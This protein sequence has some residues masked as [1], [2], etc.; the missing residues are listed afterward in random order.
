[1]KLLQG[2]FQTCHCGKIVGFIWVIKALSNNHNEADCI[3][4]MGFEPQIRT[5][6]NKIPN[7]RQTFIYTNT[8]PKEVHKIVG[9]LLIDHVQ[10]NIGN[11]N[12]IVANKT[13][14]KVIMMHASKKSGDTTCHLLLTTMLL[15]WK[16]FM[17]PSKMV[18]AFKSSVHKYMENWIYF[19]MH[20]G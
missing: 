17:K 9:D 5:I 15:F 7:Q 14:T 4:D 16:L 10:V 6:V 2:Q 13:I 12:E 19:Y 3:P 20:M 11:T 8:W 1:M 18:F